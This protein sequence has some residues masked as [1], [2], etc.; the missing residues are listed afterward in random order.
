MLKAIVTFFNLL[1]VVLVRVAQAL[2]VG[3]VIVIVINVFMRFVLD[4]GLFWAEEVAILFSTWFIFIAMGLGVKQRLHISLHIIPRRLLPKLV[5]GTLD[6]IDY[7]VALAV[8]TVMLVFGFKLVKFTSTSIMPATKWPASTQ[9]MPLILS[10][11]L[12]IYEAVMKIFN[13]DTRDAEIESKLSGD[14]LPA[15]AEERHA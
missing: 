14:D 12:I 4:S 1:H 10:G 11:I 9:Y 7:I 6:R 3:M 8:G 13:I 5:D 15:R 2:I